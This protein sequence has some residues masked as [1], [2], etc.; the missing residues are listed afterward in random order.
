MTR[1]SVSSVAPFPFLTPSS[2]LV[3]RSLD[4]NHFSRLDPRRR[5]FA[6]DD[7]SKRLARRGK[8]IEARILDRESR[9]VLHDGLAATGDQE[10]AEKEE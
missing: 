10:N 3:L 1:P 6:H 8:D 4:E 5:R 2:T 7:L 9:L